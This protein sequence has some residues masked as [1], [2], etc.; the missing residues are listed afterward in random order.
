MGAAAFTFGRQ[1]S[2]NALGGLHYWL[3]GE[4]KSAARNKRDWAAFYEWITSKDVYRK[5]EQAVWKRYMDLPM[6]PLSIL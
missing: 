3:D 4:A 2:C 6:R 1:V 5:Q